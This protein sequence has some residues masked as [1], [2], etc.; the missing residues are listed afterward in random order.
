MGPRAG[1]TRPRS[2]RRRLQLGAKGSIKGGPNGSISTS[3]VIRGLEVWT[4]NKTV[5][6]V[7]VG[8]GAADD[9]DPDRGGGGDEELM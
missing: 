4:D 2:S 9:R 3:R 1:A 5:E 6:E 8:V 7:R